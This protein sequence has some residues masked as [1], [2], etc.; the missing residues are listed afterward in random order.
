MVN[1]VLWDVDGTLLD[2]AGSI[3]EGI[4]EALVKNGFERPDE[5][6]LDAFVGPPV[7]YSLEHFTDVPRE[8]FSDIV[9]TYRAAYKTKGLPQSKLYPGMRE[10]LEKFAS[11]GYIQGVATQKPL[12]LA[13]KVVE[14]F[15]IAQFFEVVG[16]A[17]DEHGQK[18]LE[19]PSD[20]PGIIGYVLNALTE[21][22]GQDVSAVMIGD[23][24][25]DAV[26]AATHGIPSIGV[27]WGFG[28]EAER[29]EHFDNVVDTPKQLQV[30]VAELFAS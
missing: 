16:G 29:L 19:M 23:R 17:R 6:T 2:P 1:I 9:A 7:N 4:A 30:R 10:T 25:Y 22:Y 26:G 13:E 18:N 3:T 5:K 11:L 15:D 12:H 8:K 27:S 20:K 21:K 28:D 14:M 24:Q